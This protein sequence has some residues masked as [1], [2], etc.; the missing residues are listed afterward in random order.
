MGKFELAKSLFSQEQIDAICNDEEP[1]TVENYG[2]LG[3]HEN[4]QIWGLGA[5][6]ARPRAFTDEM[7]MDLVVR[8]QR[9]A[10]PGLNDEPDP[11]ENYTYVNSREIPQAFGLDTIAGRPRGFTDEMAMNFQRTGTPDIDAWLQTLNPPMRPLRENPSTSSAVADAAAPRATEVDIQ[12]PAD[13]SAVALLQIE[14]QNEDQAGPTPSKKADSKD[15]EDPRD[16]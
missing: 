15:P 14:N 6:N 2:Y 3:S 13:P 1:D 16:S 7:A 10:T 4:P 11:F 5:S 9:T 12:D 8:F